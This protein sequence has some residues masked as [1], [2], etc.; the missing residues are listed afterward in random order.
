M[1]GRIERLE[2][3]LNASALKMEAL[4]KKRISGD[5][6]FLLVR[7]KA[8]Y[9]VARKKLK[10]FADAGDEEWAIYK[11]DIWIAWY[12]LDNALRDVQDVVIPDLEN[13]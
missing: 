5:S 2:A 3:Q 4:Q 10:E 9:S 6:D 7:L 1:D 11:A 12:E 13:R 8:K